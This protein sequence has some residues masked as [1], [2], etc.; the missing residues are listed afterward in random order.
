MARLAEILRKR[1]PVVN[2]FGPERTVA[3]A[4][5][6]M[7]DRKVGCVLV[8]EDGRLVGI[9]SERDL[10]HRVIAKSRPVDRTALRDVM[11]ADPMTASP[12]ESRTAAILKM[13]DVGCRH[14][15]VL[16]EGQVIDTISIRD[17]LFDEI[18]ER[19]SE[20]QE[21]RRYIQG[22]PRSPED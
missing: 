15:P 4:V 19:D 6:R 20:I 16:E 13:Q 12:E 9:F 22:G 21:L 8:A 17:L 1:S 10:V 5:A 3:E 11:T 14:L 7:T 2:V 18:Q